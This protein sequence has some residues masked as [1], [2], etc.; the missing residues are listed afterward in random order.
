[1]S[2]MPRRC[3]PIGSALP[4]SFPLARSYAMSS[5]PSVDP[6]ASIIGRFEEQAKRQADMV[7]PIS[8]TI[9]SRW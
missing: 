7:C 5:H 2:V 1:M 6:G 8:M 4:Y 9:V 3:R